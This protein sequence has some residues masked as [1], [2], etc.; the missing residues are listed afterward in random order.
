[1]EN[2]AQLA[3]AKPQGFESLA[4]L[5]RV[6]LAL[7]ASFTLGGLQRAVE[8]LDGMLAFIAAYRADLV[9]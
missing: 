9:E 5:G 8:Q 2:P 1:M 6:V 4:Q 7:S 3:R